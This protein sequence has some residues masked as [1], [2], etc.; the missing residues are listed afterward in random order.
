M[1][2]TY[3]LY[4]H[5]YTERGNRYSPTYYLGKQFEDMAKAK[6]IALEDN[7]IPEDRYIGEVAP[8]IKTMR[9]FITWTFDETKI[10]AIDFNAIFSNVSSM[11]DIVM[12]PTPADAIVWIKKNTDLVEGT[13]WN[14]L[15]SPASTDISW[16]NI[17]A[18]TLTII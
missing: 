11:N 15:I 2:K 6:I 1:T 7:Q 4:R 10:T 14:F 8:W 16:N 18:V 9:R 3:W 12:F 13:P 17:P 5:F